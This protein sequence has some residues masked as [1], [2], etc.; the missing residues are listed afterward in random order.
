MSTP[1]VFAAPRA[2]RATPVGTRRARRASAPRTA[3]TSPRVVRAVA[4]DDKAPAKVVVVG[5]SGFVGSR[6]CDKL[7]AA[8]VADVVS[9]SKS[10]GNGGV[11]IDLSS[12]ACVTALTDAMK[13][14]DCVVSCVGVFKP[15]DDDAMREG[16][17]TYNVRVVDAA[18]AAKVDRFVYVSVASIVPDALGGAESAPVM[19]GYFAGKKM[20]EEAVANAFEDSNVCLVK[21]SFI[22]G[23]DAFSV[24]PPRVTQQYGDVLVKIL[25]SGFVKSVA[26]RSP[27]PIA[28]TLAEPVSVDDVAGAVCAGVFGRNQ[29]MSC[30]GTDEIKACAATM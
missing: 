6:V 22:F 11:A 18:V 2:P 1:A 15:G 10:G 7:R 3:A 29:K 16:N 24:N 25:G 5:G 21:P 23:G 17:G 27:G 30:D 4:S 28:L 12:D 20:T 13:G 19:A 8:G 14:A 26:Q 9:V